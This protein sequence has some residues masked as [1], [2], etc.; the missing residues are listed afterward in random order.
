MSESEEV[1]ES[2]Q[3]EKEEA[4]RGVGER[5]DWRKDEAEVGRIVSFWDDGDGDDG[6]VG[7]RGSWIQESLPEVGWEEMDLERMEWVE[8]Q[9]EMAERM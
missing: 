5:E 3:E 8:R 2:T 7:E 1:I 9:E 6:G 4:G